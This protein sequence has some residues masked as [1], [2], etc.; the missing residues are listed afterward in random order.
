[1]NIWVSLLMCGFSLCWGSIVFMR[2][3]VLTPMAGEHPVMLCIGLCLAPLLAMHPLLP[4]YKKAG[5]W[6]NHICNTIFVFI[7]FLS[8]LTVLRDLIWLG[9]DWFIPSFPSIF[10]NINNVNALTFFI[11]CIMIIWALYQGSRVP[12][13]KEVFIESNKILQ[14][15]TL[16]VLTDLHITRNT[17]DKKIKKIV[18]RTNKTNPMAVL[19]VGDTIDDKT[20]R[21]QNKIGLLKQLKASKGVF[22][23]SG[24]HEFYIGYK[25][26]IRQFLDLGFHVL[27]HKGRSLD[28]DLYI[29]GIADWQSWKKLGKK[30]D[31]VRT[32][33]RATK[34]QFKVLLSHTPGEFKKKPFEL[35]ISGH[36]HGGQIWP[37][38][39]FSSY[40]NHRYLAGL[41][42]M[43]DKAK[44]YVSR[45]T[46]HWGPQVRLFAPAEITLIHL[47]PKK[48]E[49]IDF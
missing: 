19:L 42:N 48:Q 1:M 35:Q 7:F 34:N 45:G 23:V 18:A 31:L 28:D 3:F 46:G 41:Y 26:C 5:Y 13:V 37:F 40:T 6:M 12:N 36:T 30:I 8:S 25:K 17:L 44:I 4:L 43:M 49:A 22:A 47:T 10:T 38:H 9:L 32:F 33:K 14:E 29:G 11:A 15:K 39:L 20:E 27:D 24:N 2:Y 21:I 16:A